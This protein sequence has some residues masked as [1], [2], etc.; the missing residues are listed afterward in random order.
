MEKLY[1]DLGLPIGSPPD[2][3]KQKF[4]KLARETHPDKFNGDPEKTKMFQKVEKAFSVLRCPELVIK[5]VS[6]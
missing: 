1:A 5:K 6:R 4:R 3:V 2:L